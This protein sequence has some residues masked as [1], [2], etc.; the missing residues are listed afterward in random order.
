MYL[1]KLEMPRVDQCMYLGIMVSTKE[2]I[3][4]YEETNEEV[5]R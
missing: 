2:L 1:N 3:L 4:I 5:L